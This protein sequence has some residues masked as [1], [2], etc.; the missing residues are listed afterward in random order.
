MLVKLSNVVIVP[1][2][3]GDPGQPASHYCP[4]HIPPGVTDPPDD[5]GAGGPGGG[6]GGSGSPSCP[7]GFRYVVC[8]DFG[9]GTSCEPGNQ[10]NGCVPCDKS[11]DNFAPHLRPVYVGDCN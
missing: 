8:C 6:G 9:G 3:P 2:V 11:C 1:A 5:S 4:S 10:F 7:S